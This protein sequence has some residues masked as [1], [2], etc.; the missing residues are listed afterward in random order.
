MSQ[1]FDVHEIDVKPAKPVQA[2]IALGANV[3]SAFGPPLATVEAAIAEIAAP[4][5]TLIAAAKRYKTPCF[6]VGAGDDYVNSAVIVS[7]QLSAQALLEHLHAIEARFDRQRTS[8]WASRTLDLDLL[9]YGNAVLPDTLTLKQWMALP[10]AKQI[11]TTPDQLILPHPRLHQR[12][13]VLVPLAEVAPHWAHP[14]TGQ[15]ARQMRDA[16]PLADLQQVV[17]L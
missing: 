8:R 7:T 11:E 16:L 4:E 3:A 6:P 2:A 12:A 14:L 17:P 13:F 15:T 9:F 5:I 10:P 1:P